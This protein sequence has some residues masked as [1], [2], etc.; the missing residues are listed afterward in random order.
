MCCAS[1]GA[2]LLPSF[3][4][5][6]VVRPGKGGMGDSYFLDNLHFLLPPWPSPTPLTH[7]K[8]KLQAGCGRGKGHFKESTRVSEP[9]TSPPSAGSW[10]CRAAVGW[11]ERTLTAAALRF[12]A[13]ATQN[14]GC[15]SISSQLPEFLKHGDAKEVWMWDK[16]FLDVH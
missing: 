13:I 10:T 16:V 3:R 12:A 4:E 2:E 11:G 14:K 9:H 5:S 1:S 7:T 6:T 15:L 8:K